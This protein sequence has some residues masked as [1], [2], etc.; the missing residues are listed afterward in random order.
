MFTAFTPSH[1]LR[2]LAVGGQSCGQPL[3]EAAEGLC[4]WEGMWGAQSKRCESQG[5]AGSKSA[6]KRTSEG[7]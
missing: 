2:V 4:H 6:F 5:D 1:L 3:G 7:G